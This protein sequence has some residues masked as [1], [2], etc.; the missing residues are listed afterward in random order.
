MSEISF[1]Y[2]EKTFGLDIKNVGLEHCSPRKKHEQRKRNYFSLHF[3]MYGMGTLCVNGAK[4][5]LGKG[6]A[7][8]LYANE[9]YEYYPDAFNPWSYTW[10]DFYCDEAEDLLAYC[11]F[12]REKPYVKIEDYLVMMDFFKNLVDNY[13]TGS[14]KRLTIYGYLFLVLELLIEYRN[15]YDK[16]EKKGSLFYKQFIGVLTYMNNNYRMNLSL[17]QIAEEMNISKRQLMYMF[18]TYIDLTPIDY[19]NKFRISNACDLFKQK[20]FNVEQVAEMVGIDDEKYFMRL[21]KK[22]KGVTSKEYRQNC[23]DDDPFAWLKEKN[24]DFR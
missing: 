13:S 10:I 11:G 18:K 12:S 2:N 4:H 21:F 3:V 5:L 6:T 19:M 24:I 1:E 17:D 16:V 22:I 9:E 14:V 23:E 7:F 15:R 20:E 8:V